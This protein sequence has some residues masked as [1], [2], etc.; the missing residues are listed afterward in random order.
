MI[1][2][3]LIIIGICIIIFSIAGCIGFYGSNAKKLITVN[4]DSWCELYR[5]EYREAICV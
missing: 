3:I 5:T 2:K 4:M 1:P